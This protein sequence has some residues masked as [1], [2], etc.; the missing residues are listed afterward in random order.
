MPLPAALRAA[1]S[2]AEASTVFLDRHGGMLC[3]VRATDGVRARPVRL[4]EVGDRV[5]AALLAAEDKRFHSHPGVDPLAVARSIGQFVWSRRVVSGGSTLTQQL[6]RNLVPRPRSVVGKLREMALAL[7]IE[8]SLSKDRILEEYLNRISFGP[9]IRGVEASSRY[10]FDKPTRDLSLAE[11]AALASMPRGPTLYDPRRG[12]A[13]LL[14]RRDRVLQ[15]MLDAGFATPDDVDRALAE[16]LA[17]SPRGAGQGIPHLRRA[18]LS[19][20][21]L[22]PWGP[23]SGRASTVTTTIDR[24]LQREVEILAVQTIERLAP[25][26]VSAASVVVLDNATA[27]V[28]S[29]V[30]SPNIDDEV[31]L[32]HND[33]VL[34]RRQPGSAL[35]PF[36]YGLGMEMLGFSAA[37]V[38]PDVDVSFPEPEG[39]YHPHNYD[40]RFHGP[41][42]VRE[43]LANSFNVPAVNVTARIGPEKLLKKLHDVGFSS[44]DRSAR[45]YGLALALG[46]GEVRL[47]ELAAAYATLAR[48]GVY[49]PVRAVRNAKSKNGDT[50]AAGETEPHRVFD[51][52]TVFV[53][54]DILSDRHAR[55]SSFG[56]DNVLEF[57]F[58]VAAKTG[59]SKGF[60]DNVTVGFSSRITVAV[61]VGNFDGS[62]MS[63]VSGISGA[64][65]LFHDVMLAASRVFPGESFK[66]PEGLVDV[67]VCPLSGGRPTTDCPHQRTEVVPRGMQ[68]SPC[69]MHERVRIDKRNGLR[70][71][72]ACADAFVEARVF[73]RYA[74]LYSAWAE[75]AKRPLVPVGSSPFC[76]DDSRVVATDRIRIAYPPDGS[77]FILDSSLASREAIHV[78]ADVPRSAHSVR[79]FIDGRPHSVTAPR[80]S[81]SVPLVRGRHE[82]YVEADGQRSDVVVYEVE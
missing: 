47:L 69:D 23:L 74:P 5:V 38:V 53:L 13:R 60:R 31:R 65:P 51:E 82:V 37:S 63:G 3:E 7:R 18:I 20:G 28:L 55:L 19:A 8:A 12:T 22:S 16:P 6:A 9:A 17:I 78:R 42:R 24:G 21:I 77:R 70:A 44:L 48:G 68:L 57:D 29:Y 43:A 66:R 52:R 79:I 80:W 4:A 15:R 59:T 81:H 72:P 14:R 49:M 67:Q 35:K 75:G 50:L 32:G 62:P 27:E 61:W 10:Y 30:G 45:E 54:T 46:D 34:A 36:V 76:P 71:G 40:G 11:A 26:N 56:E 25:R 33:G 58:P 73:E 2:S 41:V 64:G 1:E 39:D